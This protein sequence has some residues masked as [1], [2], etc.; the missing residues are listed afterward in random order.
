MKEQFKENLIDVD[1][2]IC[3]SYNSS[4]KKMSENSQMNAQI[5]GSTSSRSLSTIKTPK[6]SE[7]QSLIL[8]PQVNFDYSKVNRIKSQYQAKDV[9]IQANDVF[10]QNKNAQILF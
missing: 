7:E 5:N 4:L 6:I 9:F 1:D 8:S 10:I 2:E 3:M